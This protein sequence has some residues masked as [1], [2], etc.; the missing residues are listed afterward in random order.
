MRDEYTNFFSSSESQ[1]RL[2]REDIIDR[3]EALDAELQLKYPADIEASIIIVGGS[4][5]I[6]L[7]MLTRYSHD[8]DTLACSREIKDFM[9]D[10]AINDD[11]AAYLDCFPEDYKSRLI[12]IETSCS[13][14]KV[15]TP[16]LEDIVI[17]KLASP[18]P[19]DDIDIHSPAIL[20]SV[21]LELLDTLVS[22]GTVQEGFL[23]DRARRN[24][25]ID[26]E[27]FVVDVRRFRNET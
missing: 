3:L 24:F 2:Y 19:K 15:Y 23:S 1:S 7:D 11:V 10:Y 13:I 17:S 16:S 18:R 27:R 14:L 6:L 26:Y 4:A 25:Q 8:I 20:S 9:T 21:N 5:L 22:S 12:K